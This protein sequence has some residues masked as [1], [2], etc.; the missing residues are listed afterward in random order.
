MYNVPVLIGC[1]NSHFSL[2]LFSV[3]FVFHYQTHQVGIPPG[4]S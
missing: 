4:L 1:S 2:T 3:T